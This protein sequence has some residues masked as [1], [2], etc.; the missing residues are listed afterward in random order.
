MGLAPADGPS[1]PLTQG[2]PKRLGAGDYSSK[3][4]SALACKKSI[5]GERGST[6][7]TFAIGP[8]GA[9][10]FVRVSQSSGNV[11]LDQLALATVRNAAPFPP[12]PVLRDGTAAY[13]IRIDFHQTRGGKSNFAPVRQY[14][15]RI[16][17]SVALL[18]A[19]IDASRRQ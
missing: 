5:A 2:Q 13:T 11:R 10:R 8:A 12:P 14:P 9:L 1:I 19:M 4:W 18:G 15:D 17:D 7:V 16:E 3:I 6:T